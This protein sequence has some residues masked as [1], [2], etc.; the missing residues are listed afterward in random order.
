VWDRVNT[1]GNKAIPRSDD[2]TTEI[3]TKVRELME[4]AERN[5]SPTNSQGFDGTNGLLSVVRVWGRER[6][7]VGDGGGEKWTGNDWKKE[8][9]EKKEEAAACQRTKT[10][11]TGYKTGSTG[12]AAVWTVKARRKQCW[13]R[14]IPAWLTAQSARLT[15]QTAGL[16]DSTDTEATG[17]H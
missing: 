10:G 9:E 1:W 12:F 14:E 16:T 2:S 3:P 13:L 7:S 4:K 8:G 6:K 15:A 11:S 5:K 17:F